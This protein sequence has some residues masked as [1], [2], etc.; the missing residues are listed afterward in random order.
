MSAQQEEYVVHVDARGKSG[1]GVARKLRA[2]GMVPAV[3]YGHEQDAKA[4]A[5]DPDAILELFENPKGKNVVF[6]LDVEGGARIENV[7]V[8]DYQIDPV[9]RELL[10]VDFCV[11]DLERPIVRLVPIVPVGRAKGVR[12]GGILSVLRPD[13]HIKARP[14]DIP[15]QIEADVTELAPTQTILA[16]DVELP[17]GVEPGYRANYGLLT[18]V[19]P[20]K[21]K[22]TLKEEQEA[23]VADA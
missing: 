22:A 15:V 14:M 5:V 17:A 18:V 1:K 16:A 2:A 3:V 8:K 20:R 9:R 13:I 6:A 12:M 4:L 21:K 7:M 19:M 10:H 23:E 11:V